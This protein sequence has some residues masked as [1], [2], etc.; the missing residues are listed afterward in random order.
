ME[1]LTQE[2]KDKLLD[3]METHLDFAKRNI[4]ALGP[5]GNL[6]WKILWIKLAERLNKV[7]NSKTVDGWIEVSIPN[8]YLTN[9]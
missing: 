9:Y 6:L 5:Q 4:G 8:K 3:Y 7:G 1:S 2:Q